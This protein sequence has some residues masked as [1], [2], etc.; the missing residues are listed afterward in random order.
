M[1]L[2]F[3]LLIMLLFIQVTAFSAEV[4][5]KEF[6]ASHTG[7]LLGAGAYQGSNL[8]SPSGYFSIHLGYQLAVWQD[9]EVGALWDGAYNFSH[10]EEAK[11]LFAGAKLNYL[12]SQTET[13]A[14]L[15]GMEA[16]IAATSR[17]HKPI[18]YSQINRRSSDE[19]TE[20]FA[21][22]TKVG[23]RFRTRSAV[24]FEAAIRFSQTFN[25]ND[26]G[27]PNIVGISFTA[28]L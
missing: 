8:G 20:G 18:D 11:Y 14:W 5:D 2:I 3:R 25:S 26:H 17:I 7:W 6:K 23:Y 9:F 27:K 15:V 24:P 22:G 10:P 16:G 19:T 12:F 28:F 13:A 1:Q 21:L 4:P